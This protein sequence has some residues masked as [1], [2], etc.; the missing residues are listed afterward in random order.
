MSPN[1]SPVVV[2]DPGHGGTTPSGGS[3]SNNAVGPNGLLEKE[4]VLDIARRVEGLLGNR[5][6]V[7]LTRTVDE[8]RSLSDRARLARD[9]DADVFL[10]IH[11]NGW[12]DT[13]VDGSEA[14]VA[15]NAS[16][17]SRALARSVLDRVVG[18][19]HA[20]DRGVHEEN[21]GVLLPERQGPRTAASLLELAFLTNAD[22]AGRLTHE[23]Y[24]QALAQAISEGIAAE[25]KARGTAPAAAALTATAQQ[26]AIDLVNTFRAETGAGSFTPRR[27]DV[28]D[29]AIELINDPTLVQQGA[30]N[31]C[32][33]AALHHIWIGRDPAAFAR[34]VTTLYDTGEG[35]IGSL[36]VDAGGDLRDQDYDGKAVP[37]M[38]GSVCPSADWVAMSAL[39]DS[40]NA[41]LDFEGMPSEDVAGLTTPAE[42]ADWLRATGLYTDVSDEGNWYFTKGLGHALGLRP[43]PDTD[44]VMLINAHVLTSAAVVGHKKSDNFILSAFPNHFVV[45]RS[46]VTQPTPGE[47]EFDCWTWGSN[48]H[49]RIATSVFEANY[50]GAAIAN[51]TGPAA[52]SSALAAGALA[53]TGPD[54]VDGIDCDSRNRLPGWADLRAD[55]IQFAV[56]KATEG[57]TYV[58][59]GTKPDSVPGGSFADRRRDAHATH[60]PVGSYHYARASGTLADA[61]D[62]LRAQAS[63]LIR[64]VGRLVPGDLPPSYDFEE[65]HNLDSVPWRDAEWLAPM[66][67]FLDLVETALGRVPMIYTSRRIWREYIHDDAAFDRFGDYPLW[68]VR[69]PAESQRFAQR[70]TLD[71]PLPAPWSDWAILQYSGDFTPSEFTNLHAVSPQMDLN[72]SNGSIHVLRGL[73][74]LGRPAPHG[75]AVRFVAYADENG[76]I[77]V[78]TFVGYWLEANLTELARDPSAVQGPLAAGDVAACEVGDRQYIA[79]RGRDDGHLYEIERNGA[80]IT[81]T[82][83]SATVVNVGTGFDPAG[84]LPAADPTYLAHGADRTIVYWGEDNSQ[85]L[86]RNNG[87]T[88]QATLDATRGSQSVAASGNAA[89][90]F[91]DDSSIGIVAR[92]GADGHLV[93]LGTDG[94]AWTR[95]DLTAQSPTAVAATY[96]PAPYQLSDGS[97]LVVYR[98]VRGELHQIRQ[99]STDENLSQLAGGA[100]TCAGN[101]VAFVLNDV[102]HVVYRRPNGR[103]HEIA[104]DGAGG[105]MHRELPCEERAAAD[106]A[107]S[108][109]TEGGRPAA[110]VV[111]RGRSGAFHEATLTA[112]TWSCVR[113]EPAANEPPAEAAGLGARA[114]TAPP[115]PVIVAADST[116]VRPDRVVPATACGV[117]RDGNGAYRERTPDKVVIHVLDDNNGYAGDIASWQAGSSC[118]PPHYVIRNDGEITQMVAEKYMAQHAG[119]QGNPTMI[120]IEHDGW[121]NDPAYFTEAMYLSSAALVRDICARHRI[122]VDREHV[123]GHDEVPGTTHGDP[124]GYWDWDY[125]VALLRWDGVDQATKPQ[126]YVVDATALS[127]P[128]PTAD[129]HTVD[130]DSGRADWK[131]RRE[132]TGSLFTSAYGPRYVRAQGALDA[133]ADDRVEFRFVAPQAGPWATSAWWPI[134]DDANTATRFEVAVTTSG[135]PDRQSQSLMIDQSATAFRTRPTIALPLSPTWYPL[136]MLDLQQYDEVI[137]RVFRRS[138]APGKVIADA[139]RF[140]KT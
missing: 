8:N 97:V 92:A 43:A 132:E 28:A 140:L 84:R 19:T 18:V 61:P 1:P 108:I 59:D 58:D 106:P 112:A 17:S 125:Y 81:L 5:A 80:Q 118:T 26:E 93:E 73:A 124:G 98:A 32:G 52:T 36:E 91:A 13:N 70:L 62:L 126:R 119:P 110:F 57:Q 45:L 21:L 103:L 111:F 51:V 115:T 133:P 44:V 94:T 34:Y 87:G 54:R 134:L 114:L 30:L 100:P 23:D 99:D 16:S 75:T 56:F 40:E 90:F 67:A 88:W 60:V 113:I 42:M 105:W 109:A 85:Y 4:V 24:K 49:V 33:P 3:S 129:W 102:P 20:R 69:W 116:L 95:R 9:A 79:F 128:T 15:R 46:A 66:E 86:L 14:W 47:V 121:D 35:Q 107:A 27:N 12:K 89:V 104:G 135:N 96:R 6:R 11:M 122:P 72:V 136:P 123:I 120:G 63:N 82:D 131:Q 76:T 25:L 77:L 22:E 48:V 71:P 50:Y 130:R 64:T 55:G 78:L 68:V 101:P 65:R 139:V 74:D 137:V 83:L 127:G 41:V 138:D 10:S 38:G 53:S 37:A 117:A 29:R 39:R 7:I 2:I 31:L